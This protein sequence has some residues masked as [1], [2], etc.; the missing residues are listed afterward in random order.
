VSRFGP[1]DLGANPRNIASFE[2]ALELFVDKKWLQSIIGWDDHESACLAV[3]VPEFWGRQ[4]IAA[5]VLC[6]YSE[7]A[8]MNFTNDAN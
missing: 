5:E 3:A 7:R 6:S 1:C 4:A 2:A 8:I